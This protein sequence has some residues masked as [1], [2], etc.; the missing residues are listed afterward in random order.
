MRSEPQAAGREVGLVVLRRLRAL[1][2]SHP[3]STHDCS[4]QS[5][6]R[7][8]A[9][10]FAAPAAASSFPP[11]PGLT[12]VA[13]GG[14]HQCGL[15]WGDQPLA[16]RIL[17]HVSSDTVLRARPWSPISIPRVACVMPLQVLGLMRTCDGTFW[18][19]AC[20][21]E[22]CPNMLSTSMA[23]ACQWAIFGQLARCSECQDMEQ[24][25]Q[26]RAHLDA[27]AWL[28]DFQL[29]SHTPHTPLRPAAR[30]QTPIISCWARILQG[31]TAQLHL[32][33]GK[34]AVRSRSVIGVT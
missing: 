20:C 25:V 1:M 22:A 29:S 18:R 24:V 13:A 5:A 32:C 27:A 11:P 19:L 6:S 33:C 15:P 9:P 16:L 28:H 2:T 34:C 3:G 4:T 7:R 17:N 14:L 30:T 8:P 12:C 23:G 10:A 26:T 31:G 21:H